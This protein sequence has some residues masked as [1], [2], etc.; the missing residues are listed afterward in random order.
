MAPSPTALARSLAGT[1]IILVAGLLVPSVAGAGT[2][3]NPLAPGLDV[4]PSGGRVTV[5]LPGNKLRD[6]A[7]HQ[8]GLPDMVVQRGPL[9]GNTIQTE[10]LQ[11]QLR[12]VDPQLGTIEV[13]AGRNF[14]LP[15]S[16]GQITNVLTDPAG[17]FQSG[18][19]F[20]DVFIEVSLPQ[21]NIIMRG[22][23]PFRM[24]AKNIRS[25]PP[26]MPVPTD[27]QAFTNSHFKCYQVRVGKT[28][29]RRVTLD[30]QFEKRKARTK[31]PFLLCNPV[32]KKFNTTTSNILN[33][34]DHLV[35][36]RITPR[37]KGFEERVV[38]IR[39]QF[40]VATLETKRRD[41][42]CLP[43]TKRKIRRTT[44]RIRLPRPGK[45]DHFKCYRASHRGNALS[46]NV[47][48]RD[49]F[50]DRREKARG[51]NTI[52]NPVE[53]KF[54]K[55]TSKVRNE[56][57]H[58]VMHPIKKKRVRRIV[59]VRNQFGVQVLRVLKRYSLAVPTFKTDCTEYA[60]DAKIA[61]MSQGNL[62][63]SVTHAV[64]VPFEGKQDS[65]CPG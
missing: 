39:N 45:L 17:N 64:H 53:K 19:S 38:G 51:P 23:Q 9:V 22:A 27:Q 10:I 13:T 35:C 33:R 62:I 28:P 5:E 43:S 20:F 37:T 30:D 7:L 60:E 31:K 11:L 58:L 25:L 42:L 3:V 59:A 49:Q 4:F 56:V 16:V 26:N 12:G 15:P 29:R 44:R 46:F 6:I 54:G 55:R 63:A 1:C 65:P 24:E 41:V 48:L 21:S 14:G 8:D 36:Y 57:G 40:G 32:R 61:L 18:D 2:L 34:K 47:E 50:E 52:C